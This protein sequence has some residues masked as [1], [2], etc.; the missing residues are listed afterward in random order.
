MQIMFEKQT[1]LYCDLES[2]YFPV[3]VCMVTPKLSI[4]TGAQQRF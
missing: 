1:R 2:V 3:E 4:L